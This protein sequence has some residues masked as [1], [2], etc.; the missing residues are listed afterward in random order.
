M[1][2]PHLAG[3]G[4]PGPAAVWRDSRRA[5]R[6]CQAPCRHR[7]GTAHR[8]HQGRAGLPRVILPGGHRERHG[9]PAPGD[10]AGPS[11]LLEEDHGRGSHGGGQVTHARIRAEIRG[12]PGEDGG[13]DGQR[14]VDQPGDR[15]IRGMAAEGREDVP[16]RA[17]VGRPLV[18][19]RTDAGLPEDRPEGLGE[20]VRRP[21]LGRSAR[22]WVDHDDAAAG[23]D[24]DPRE[25]GH[26]VVTPGGRQ[27]DGDE[28]AGRAG[29]P[30]RERGDQ[31]LP[32]R[33]RRAGVV[34][35]RGRDGGAR[36]KRAE[37]P[38]V[39][40]VA[41]AEPRHHASEAAAGATG[42]QAAHR[43]R[44]APRGRSRRTTP[45]RP[46]RPRRRATARSAAAPRA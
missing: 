43:R 39:R 24:A 17:L 19:H 21:E 11:L 26:G 36:A 27:S 1:D 45:P 10:P 25:R 28:R 8:L 34:R 35:D 46:R 33:A 15:R 16:G 22:A 4:Q 3:L 44:R 41:G 20:L 42:A 37:R 31:V 5:A 9:R 40:V 18:E 38:R 29:A 13:Q 6:G 12:G 2:S 23:L 7:T 14:R 30:R 32:H